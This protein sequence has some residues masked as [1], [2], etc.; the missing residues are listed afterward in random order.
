MASY[1]YFYP[2]TPSSMESEYSSIFSGYQFPAGRLSLTTNI[3]TGNQ[4]DEV[5]KLLNAGVKNVEVSLVNKQVFDQ[6]PKQHMK[7]IARLTKLTG[8][9]VSLHAPFADM[10]DLSGFSQQG[11]EWNEEQRK[12]VEREMIEIVSRGNQ[13]CDDGNVNI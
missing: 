10:T 9:K 7:E 3:G 5:S 4:L 8:S 12:S 13:I 11:G 1:E 2:G 6:I